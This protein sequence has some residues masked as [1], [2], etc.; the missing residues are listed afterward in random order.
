MPNHWHL[1]LWPREDNILSAFVQHLSSQHVRLWRKRWGTSGHLYQGRFKSIPVQSDEY[2]LN[3]LRYIEMNPVRAG[4]VSDA[5]EWQWSSAHTRKTIDRK[6]D[7]SLCDGPV[8]PGPDWI[9][10]LCDPSPEFHK[11]LKESIVRSR[12]LGCD[13]WVK[14]TAERLKTQSSLNSHGGD[15][16]S[17]TVQGA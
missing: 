15:R 11:L 1:A 5:T 2:Y 9:T 12:P 8:A 16:R 4:L 7:V 13:A 3:L 14:Q 10:K 17:K 6:A